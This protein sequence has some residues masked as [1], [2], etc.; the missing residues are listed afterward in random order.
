MTRKREHTEI[1]CVS[2]SVFTLL[3]DPLKKKYRLEIESFCASLVSGA[4]VLYPMQL[5]VYLRDV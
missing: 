3:S 4:W 1:L 5:A 2:V